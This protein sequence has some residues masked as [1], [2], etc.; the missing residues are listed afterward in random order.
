LVFLLERRVSEDILLAQLSSIA[1]REEGRGRKIRVGKRSCFFN[2]EQCVG[3]Q[4]L[5][6]K[7]LIDAFDDDAMDCVGNLR[8]MVRQSRLV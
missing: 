6:T 4:M 3:S 2:I 5:V 8:I 7:G 1:E